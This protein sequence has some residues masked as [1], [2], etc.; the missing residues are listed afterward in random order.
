MDVLF[1]KKT[2]FTETELKQFPRKI[3]E[4]RE[5]ER[6]QREAEEQENKVIDD[7][8][9][10]NI[11]K[12][13]YNYEDELGLQIDKNSEFY[14]KNKEK[15]ENLDFLDENDPINNWSLKIIRDKAP[16]I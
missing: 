14:K 5:K 6:L 13:E 12:Q 11:S 8:E 1:G 4:L 9:H 16:K 3:R 15:I 2:E 7:Y 10:K